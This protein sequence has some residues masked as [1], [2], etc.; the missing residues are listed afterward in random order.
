MKPAH[1]PQPRVLSADC[2][3]RQ[4]LLNL[5]SRWGGLVLLALRDGTLRFSQLRQQVEGVSEKM[6]VQTL[7]AL[8]QDGFVI[9][10]VYAQVP[11]RV[12]YRLSE[13]G[14]QAAERFFN[15]SSWIEQALPQILAQRQSHFAQ[16]S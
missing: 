4:I 5:S 13:F 11:P 2:P 7:K 3:S 6:L 10:Q 15:L 9:R 8:E 1:A 16:N 14:I 12:E